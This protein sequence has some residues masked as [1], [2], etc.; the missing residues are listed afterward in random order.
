[1]HLSAQAGLWTVS[2]HSLDSSKF[3]DGDFL[4]I[5]K[6]LMLY[7][8]WSSVNDLVSHLS[9]VSSQSIL[10]SVQRTLSTFQD[11]LGD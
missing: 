6:Y 2:G 9:A 7:V 3:P 10:T 4:E 8:S 5:I 11:Y 1:M